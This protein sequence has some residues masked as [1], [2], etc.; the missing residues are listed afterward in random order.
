MIVKSHVFKFLPYKTFE[1][2]AGHRNYKNLVFEYEY[3]KLHNSLQIF[4][5]QVL[6]KIKYVLII[7]N[8]SS[9]PFRA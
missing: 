8:N 4:T 9:T 1:S 5:A 2:F 3:L 6:N 7:C